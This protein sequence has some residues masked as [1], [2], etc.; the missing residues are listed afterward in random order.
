LIARFWRGVVFKSVEP[1]HQRPAWRKPHAP[2]L[3]GELRHL[4]PKDQSSLVVGAAGDWCR[5]RLADQAYESGAAF[6]KAMVGVP[7]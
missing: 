6:G 1:D 2:Q 4:A 5:G 7:A 3:I